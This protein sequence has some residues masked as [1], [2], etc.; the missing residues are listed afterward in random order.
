MC[1]AY[2]M[3]TAPLFIGLL[4]AAALSLAASPIARAAP[5]AKPDAALQNVRHPEPPK[6]IQTTFD[7]I[8]KAIKDNDQPAFIAQG[9]EAFRST[10]VDMVKKVHD[11][12]APR[13]AKGM[14]VTYLG[15]MKAKGYRVDLWKLSFADG[16][17][18]WLANMSTRDGVVGG[19][20]FG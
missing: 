3:K 1:H 2:A 7:K 20:F 15:D 4:V 17:D 9:D 5:E 11:I 8:W 10:T 14:T 18:D 6:S 12:A 19:F 13:L 16:G